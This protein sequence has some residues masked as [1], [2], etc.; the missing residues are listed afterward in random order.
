MMSTAI[1]SEALLHEIQRIPR[2]QF[3][4]EEKVLCSTIIGKHGEC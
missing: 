3:L 4:K 1:H 2:V